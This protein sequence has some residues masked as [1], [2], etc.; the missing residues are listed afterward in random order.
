M[1]K[2]KIICTIG[3]AS[4]SPEMINGL[5][6]EG[7][8]VARLNF[9]HGTHKEHAEK[10]RHIRKL[11]L[12]LECRVAILQDLAGP[13][14]RIGDI[15]APGIRLDPGQIFTLTNQSII[16]S[17]EA[18]S[19]TYSELPREVREGDQILLS[20]G[21]L[22]LKVL[23]TT[24]SDIECEVVI[25]GWLSSHKGINI[26][27]GTIRA[28]S[29]TEKDIQDLKFGLEQEVDI[30]ALS[31]VR[32]AEEIVKAKEIIAKNKA[33]T[34]VIA[35]IEKHEAL[36]NLDAILKVADGIMVAR[37]DL[38]VEIPLEKVPRVQKEI[39]R[40]ANA[41]GK[42]VIT[43]T[44]MLR[45][46]VD[47]TRPTR[48]EAADVANAILDGT[49]AVMLS[50]ETATGRYPLKALEYMSLIAK[51]TEKNYPHSRY[52]EVTGKGWDITESVAHA[53]CM[54]A[55]HLNVKAIIAFTQSGTTAQEL[56]RFR[57]A[58]QI[59]AL[60]PNEQ[61]LRRLALRW[62]VMPC[63]IPPL[64]DTDDIIEKAA[65]A[66][67]KTKRVAPGD[68]IV[69]TAGLPILSTGTTNMIRVKRL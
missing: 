21:T 10:I 11:S 46:M 44:Q 42:P 64:S 61:T 59:I 28:P 52:L 33:N 8:D 19:L 2:T 45:S 50:E 66:A 20:D 25:G 1:R 37:G 14:I 29:L 6:R 67:L 47:S 35:K 7:M 63:Y 69:I 40:K 56:S 54:L 27:S 57:P 38:G 3:P 43:A 18:V 68:T 30:V 60:S 4:D 12:D 32:W 65:E 48:A 49:D 24:S 31:F 34:P 26:P 41:A 23:H 22:E 53:A 9:S 5:I 62:N 13:K 58:Q 36:K 39:I 55:N 17:K 16:G 15:P 51:E